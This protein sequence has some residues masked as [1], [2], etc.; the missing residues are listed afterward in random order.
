AKFCRRVI[1][2]A[3]GEILIDGPTKVVFSKPEILE[4]ASIKPPQITRLCQMLE[5]LKFP[6]DILTPEEFYNFM[7]NEL[8]L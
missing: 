1:L 6:R 2:M 7:T 8:M 3:R 4:K 5:D